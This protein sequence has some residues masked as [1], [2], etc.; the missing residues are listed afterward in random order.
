M[1]GL[2]VEVNL[3]LHLR[4]SE[5]K[6][7]PNKKHL[8]NVFVQLFVSSGEPGRLAVLG[9]RSLTFPCKTIESPY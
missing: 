7:A 9:E 1:T 6:F 3:L 8:S 4:D 2:G 5:V